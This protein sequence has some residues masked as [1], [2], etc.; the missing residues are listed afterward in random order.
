MNNW[1]GKRFGM[2]EVISEPYRKNGRILID[3]KC[4]CGNVK[5]M[6]LEYLKRTDINTF[7][8]GCLKYKKHNQL[9][10]YMSHYD[11]TYVLLNNAD[12][13][14][15]KC[16]TSVWEKVKQH[17]W[18]FRGNYARTTI[19]GKDYPFH[20]IFPQ[21]EGKML[22][23]I[24]QD[25]LNNFKSNLR[26]V[27]R[28]QNALNSSRPARSNTGIHGVTKR[29]GYYECNYID[30]GT[31]Y[32][33][34]VQTLDEAKEFMDK[35]NHQRQLELESLETIEQLGIEPDESVINPKNLVE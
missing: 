32:R 31:T 13:V 33:H 20:R 25:K 14:W 16:N 6:R 35:I 9:N 1:L 24:D 21:Q 34:T 11:T 29:P 19:N 12:N 3:V 22:D 4:D 5:S 18:S 28:S 2:L 10:T 30:H 26:Y 8:C 7:S 27:D 23:H 15:M 17:P